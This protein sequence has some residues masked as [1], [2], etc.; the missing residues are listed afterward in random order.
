MPDKMWISYEH[1][2]CSLKIDHIITR[3]ASI[4]KLGR[5]SIKAITETRIHLPFVFKTEIH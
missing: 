2:H 3:V 1:Y 5:G 4:Q